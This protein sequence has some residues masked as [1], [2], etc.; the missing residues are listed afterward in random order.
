M[1]L[2]KF[3]NRFTFGLLL[4]ALICFWMIYGDLPQFYGTIMIIAVV[5]MSPPMPI[6]PALFLLVYFGINST[7]KVNY[8][9]ATNIH[10][11]VHTVLGL[12]DESV[13]DY[14]A[15]IYITASLV[16]SLIVS[17]FKFLHNRMT[18][19]QNVVQKD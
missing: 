6:G 16:L 1:K 10:E 17:V 19:G 11:F 3:I 13:G 8:S 5:V 12:Y 9:E 7:Y 15:L 4:V 14:G 2:K 18:C